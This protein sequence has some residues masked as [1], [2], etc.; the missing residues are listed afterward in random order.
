MQETTIP[1]A[2]AGPAETHAIAAWLLRGTGAGPRAHVQGG[3]HADEIPPMLVLHH[4]LPMLRTAEAQGR[5]RGDITVVPQANPIGIRQFSHN[6]LLGRF[7]AASGRNFNRGFPQ[8]AADPPTGLTAW[9][10]ALL[11]VSAEADIVLDLHTDDEALPY[12]YVHG[13]MWP[14][15]KDLAAALGAQAVILWDGDGGGAFEDAVAARWLAGASGV[16]N[17]VAGRLVSTVELRGQA[18]VDDAMAS[19]DAEAL[20][21]L[22]C[23]RGVIYGDPALPDWRGEVVQATHMQTI[24]APEA[25]VLVF[26]SPLGARLAA[27]EPFAR[28]VPRPGDP[29]ADLDL[30]APHAGRLLTRSRDRYVAAGGVA[31]KLTGDAP[32]A[33]WSGGPLDD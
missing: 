10:A 28:L 7:D 25:G 33:S 13:A 11:R 27:G 4:L 29:A 6:R 12:L 23:A 5:L 3:V 1:F 32:S 19:G 30:A 8:S 15:A 26:T 24:R 17:G 22:L 14:E 16:G 20:F 9:Q 31:A 2:G 18:D 21:R